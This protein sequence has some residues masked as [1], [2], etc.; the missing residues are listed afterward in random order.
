MGKLGSKKIE[1]NVNHTFQY[2][3]CAEVTV[4][5]YLCLV[6]PSETR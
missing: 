5:I 1:K 6:N 2:L 3:R 4:P